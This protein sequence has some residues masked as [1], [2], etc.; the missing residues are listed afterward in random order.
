MCGILGGDGKVSRGKY[1]GIAPECNLIVGKVL[2]QN[3]DGDLDVLC[4]AIHWVLE[5]KDEYHIRILNISIGMDKDA[6]EDKDI[7]INELLRQTWEEGILVVVSAGNSGPKLMSLSS[8]GEVAE[9]I[10]VGCHDRDYVAKN[11]RKCSEYSSRGPGIE[12]I[13][14]PNIVAPGTEIVSCN[15]RYRKFHGKNINAYCRKSGTSMATPIVSGAAALI[16]QKWPDLTNQEV[17]RYLLQTADDLGLSWYEQG[18]G[19]LNVKK[20][21][22]KRR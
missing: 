2:D 5:K 15:Y 8:L 19:F 3:G 20:A 16:M 6:T 14:K 21:L 22:E 12:A 17:K 7:V 10:T 18:S 9:I 1:R 13:K 11:G 4:R